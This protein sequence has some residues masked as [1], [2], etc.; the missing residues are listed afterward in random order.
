M[1]TL[2][3]AQADLGSLSTLLSLDESAQR[4]QPLRCWSAAQ[5]DAVKSRFVA[6][7]CAWEEEW[8]PSKGIPDLQDVKV[9]T[10]QVGRADSESSASWFYED[11]QAQVPQRTTSAA[12]AALTRRLFDFDPLALV[13]MRNMP[14]ITLAVAQAAL[15]DWLE[16]VRQALGATLLVERNGQE[17]RQTSAAGAWS[18]SLDISLPWCDGVWL[19]SMPYPAV[20]MVLGSE[21]APPRAARPASSKP[22][23]LERALERR[24]LQ[25]RVVLDDTQLSLGQLR[26]LRVGDVITLGHRLD[27][28][29]AL[30]AENGTR[31][32][33]AWLGQLSGQVAVELGTLPAAASDRDNLHSNHHS[34]KGQSNDTSR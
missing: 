19:L 29:A 23:P 24:R 26:E 15:D 4:A 13:A 33:D 3:E 14:Q 6:L 9:G 10:V 32:C 28:P 2:F 16:R 1:K 7:L 20:A 8:L 30:V 18:G 34:F 12:L 31:I 5:Q 11:A 17:R 21:R 27:A 25:V 22:V